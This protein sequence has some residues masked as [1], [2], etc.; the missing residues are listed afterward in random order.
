VD[1]AVCK[2]KWPMALSDAEPLVAS[3]DER[4]KPMPNSNLSF[5]QLDQIA[6][7]GI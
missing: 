3:A 1:V 4:A 5:E 6:S 7:A 2:A